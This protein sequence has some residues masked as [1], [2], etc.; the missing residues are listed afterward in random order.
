LSTS[1]SA[2]R[3]LRSSTTG[4]RRRPATAK[5]VYIRDLA[6]RVRSGKL[7]LKQLETIPDEEVYARLTE[8]KGIG[9]W[10]AQM[11]LIFALRRLDILPA[12][13]LGI[14]AAIKKAYGLAGNPTPAEIVELARKW[15]PYSTVA[16]RYLWR[17]LETKA[18]L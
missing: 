5:I 9:T 3:W 13:D 1:S 16:S 2:A 6:R 4:W 18:G 15:S 17:S 14:R 8:L 10:T 7:D 11:F 12:A